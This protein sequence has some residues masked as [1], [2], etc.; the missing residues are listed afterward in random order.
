MGW[1]Q[2]IFSLNKE[3]EYVTKLALI[4]E[5][6]NAFDPEELQILMRELNYTPSA[7]QHSEADVESFK[8]KLPESSKDRFSIIYYLVSSFMKNGALSEK[9][10][11]LIRKL[12]SGLELSRE[13]AAELVSFLKMN[14]RNGL[15]E[16][17][18]FSRLGYLLERAKYA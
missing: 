10:E 3:K 13:K 15:S 17:D 4:G 7:K 18:S 16:E 14:I 6:H 5:A 1:I 8:L 12:I 11:S 2:S 9:K